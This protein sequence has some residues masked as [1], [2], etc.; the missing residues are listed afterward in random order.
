MKEILHE[1]ESAFNIISTISVKGNDVDAMAV[2]RNKLK[3]IYSALET[4][5]KD[6]TK[7]EV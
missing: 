1:L 6:D 5:S 7:S 4:R 3:K 2:A